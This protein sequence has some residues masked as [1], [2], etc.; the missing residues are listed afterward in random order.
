MKVRLIL[1]EG[2]E[3]A[4]L[5]PGDTVNIEVGKTGPQFPAQV[6]GTGPTQNGARL[7]CPVRFHDHNGKPLRTVLYGADRGTP[8]EGQLTQLPPE[9]VELLGSANKPAAR[10]PQPAPEPSYATAA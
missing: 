5:K 1:P 6:V 9:V 4:D 2:V 8:M 3:P 10:A 7:L